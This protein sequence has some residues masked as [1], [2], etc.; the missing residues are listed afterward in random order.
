MDKAKIRSKAFALSGAGRTF[1]SKGFHSLRHTFVSDLANAGVAVDLRQKLAGH[2]DARVHAGYTHHQ[3]ETL[4]A[5][6]DMLP[7]RTA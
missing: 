7:R 5:A 6:V 3:I 2:A 4:R 1:Y